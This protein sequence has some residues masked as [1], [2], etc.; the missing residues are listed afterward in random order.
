MFLQQSERFVRHH[1]VGMSKDGEQN[2]LG[3][4]VMHNSE[5]MAGQPV[6][7]LKMLVK[8]GQDL[9]ERSENVGIEEKFQ[10]LGANIRRLPA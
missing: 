9:S 4:P 6:D 3:C 2:S 1:L 5:D 7:L 8:D 10:Q